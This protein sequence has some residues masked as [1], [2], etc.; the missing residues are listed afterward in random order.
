MKG[1]W[2]AVNMLTVELDDHPLG[3]KQRVDGEAAIGAPDRDTATRRRKAVRSAKIE[4]VDLQRTL[5]VA[6]GREREGRME[7]PLAVAPAKTFA[8]SPQFADIDQPQ[9]R[10]LVDGTLEAMDI[11]KLRE[12]DEGAVQGGRGNTAHLRAI[13]GE[14][15]P[16]PVGDDTARTPLRPRDRH[17]FCAWPPAH[18]PPC[19]RRAAMA[20]HRTVTGRQHR[21]HAVAIGSQRHAAERV[22]APQLAA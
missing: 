11:R 22:D 14:E 3:S 10:R 12:I 8:G 6:G 17:V 2:R 1:A 15:P 20:E 18:Q 21:G 13:F 19:R 4:E 9:D 16:G 7:Q 5:R